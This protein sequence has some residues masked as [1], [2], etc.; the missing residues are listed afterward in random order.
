MTIKRQFFYSNIRMVLITVG[1]L[2]TAFIVSRVVM[3]AM[4]RGYGFRD[5]ELYRRMHGNS[6]KPPPTSA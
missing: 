2:L 5:V 1:G 3:N 4:L 6:W